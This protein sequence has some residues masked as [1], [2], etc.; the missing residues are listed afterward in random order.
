MLRLHWLESRLQS[1]RVLYPRAGA[2]EW[3]RG[4]LQKL[5]NTLEEDV[6]DSIPRGYGHKEIRGF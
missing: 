5:G 6:R 1:V 2:G 4:I 3:S